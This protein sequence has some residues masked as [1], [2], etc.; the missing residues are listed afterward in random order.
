MPPP[1]CRRRRRQH[2]PP[3]PPLENNP[4]I[5]QPAIQPLLPPVPVVSPQPP[6]QIHHH[7]VNETFIAR[8]PFNPEW[9]VHSLGKMDRLCSYC[10]AMH[11]IAEKLTNSSNTNPWFGMC[12]FQRKIKL[13]ELHNVPPELNHLFTSQT[14]PAKDFREN[15]CRY[16]NAL[17]M[18]SLGC[19]VDESVN[20]GNGP[21]VFKVHGQLSHLA[22]SLL[23][24]EGE[25]PVYAQLYIYDPADAL[26]H[27]MQH[28]ANQGL[29]HQTMAELQ[30]MLY[31]LHPGVQ[32]YK[33]A[34]E[35]TRGMPANQQCRIALYYDRECNQQRYN[36]PTAAS[37]E[38]AVILPGNGDEMQG[39]R[40]IVL[41]LCNGQGLQWINDLHPFYQALH[42]VLLFPTG[43]FGWNPNIPYT[44]EDNEAEDQD[45][46]ALNNRRS[47]VS[48]TEYFRYS[49]FPRI[50]ESKHIFMAG[51]L[52]QEWIVDSWAL[53]EQSRLRWIKQNQ[54]QLLSDSRRGLMDAVTIDPNATGENIGQRTI[55]PSSFSGSTR[56]M[57]QNCQDALAI[58]C[59]FGGECISV[60]ECMRMVVLEVE[61]K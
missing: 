43:Q 61:V 1:V 30:D 49:L 29:N 51:K 38:I 54:A 2:Q 12:C 45:P 16:N 3:P 8:Q 15:I 42:Y 28:A 22:G 40:D 10:S 17:A 50:N 44:S 46:D 55:L 60:C 4:D 21:Y 57:I 18:T 26:N 35:I 13:A 53:S 20:R 34:Y 39:S 24:Q 32:L 52:L 25:S 37:N 7:V 56:N 11:W 58:N 23:P 5:I 41:Y 14:P 33:Q 59:Y 9:P 47:C 27:H 36:L 48:Q 6:V 31:H 19:K